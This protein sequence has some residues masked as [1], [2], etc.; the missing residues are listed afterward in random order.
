VYLSAEYDT[1]FGVFSG[2]E[3]FEGKIEV[4]NIDQDLLLE[5]TGDFTGWQQ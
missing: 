2:D 4:L 5:S 1:R 3:T